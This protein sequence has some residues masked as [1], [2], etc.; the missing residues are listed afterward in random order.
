MF[1][2]MGG[3]YMA[4]T[5]GE[6]KNP[7]KDVPAAMSFVYLVPLTSYP[8]AMIAAGANVNYADPNLAKI[9]SRGNG[10]NGPH[11]LS[12]FV[13]AVQNTTL[14]GL[15]KALNLFFVISAYTAA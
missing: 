3:D 1:S 2:C 11:P 13:I 5:A 7:Y 12:P 15:P 4:V 8:F 6:A 9:Y 10:P 14:H